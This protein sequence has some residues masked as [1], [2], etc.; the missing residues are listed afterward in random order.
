MVAKLR[1]YHKQGYMICIYTARNMRTYDGNLGKINVHT[2][3]D[4]LDWLVLHKIPHDEVIV[5]KPWCGDEG[6]YVDDKAVRP[7]EFVRLSPKQIAE[8]ISNESDLG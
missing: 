4:I 5:G 8:L 2:L 6:F 7:S 3:P 1:E